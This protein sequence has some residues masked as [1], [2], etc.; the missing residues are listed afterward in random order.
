M[1]ALVQWINEGRSESQKNA[2][3]LYIQELSISPGY[4]S[5]ESILFVTGLGRSYQGE[6]T[7]N[8]NDETILVE[9]GAQRLKE[10]L[11]SL[12]SSLM[13]MFE[14]GVPIVL[15]SKLQC[16][17]KEPISGF[18][19]RFS[20]DVTPCQEYYKY[21][22]VGYARNVLGVLTP[23][24]NHFRVSSAVQAG[25]LS[26]IESAVTVII[27]DLFPVC[28]ANLCQGLFCLL[29][30]DY[31]DWLVGSGCSPAGGGSALSRLCVPCQSS[32]CSTGHRS[33][34][35]CLGRAGFVLVVTCASCLRDI[36][37]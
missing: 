3:D 29:A 36:R 32:C 34:P 4:R 15:T 20:C 7:R 19:Q 35:L 10:V 8:A 23:L 33:F 37:E 5:R 26:D 11:H 25:E 27:S 1:H 30:G 13:S 21:T 12:N 22:A 17:K 2:I 6:F 16:R 31:G 24:K 18:L 28:V 9:I 14:S